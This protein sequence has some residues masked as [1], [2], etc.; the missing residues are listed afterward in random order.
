MVMF[1]LLACTAYDPKDSALST[2][3]TVGDSEIESSTT[4]DSP[5]T[6][7]TGTEPPP[8]ELVIMLT[9]DAMTRTFYS[10]REENYGWDITPF[11]D[12]LLSEGVLMPNV[13]SSRALTGVSLGTLVTGAWPKHT[14]IRDNTDEWPDLVPTIQD[15]FRANGYFTVMLASNRCELGEQ[16][17]DG[18]GWDYYE[19]FYQERDD[20]GPTQLEADATLVERFK[21]IVDEH[22]GEK[23]YVWMHLM[24]PHEDYETVE[25][26]FTEYHPEEYRGRL[27]GEIHQTIDDV[28]LGLAEYSDADAKYINAVYASAIRENDD[29]VR[30]VVDFLQERGLYDNTVLA[31][32]ADHGQEFATRPDKLYFWHG[33][34]Y[35]NIAAMVQWFIK[36]PTLPV[37]TLPG[38][39]RSVDIGPTMLDLAGI[40]ADTSTFDGESIRTHLED[41]SDPENDGFVERGMRAAGIVSGKYK[42]IL[43][44]DEAFYQC[45]PYTPDYEYVTPDVEL[46]DLDRDLWEFDNLVG[47]EP[48]IAAEMREKLCSYIM[49]DSWTGDVAEDETNALVRECIRG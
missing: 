33:C 45:T 3:D 26:W 22:P 19:C 49:E 5:T 6:T 42:Y 39:H 34:T 44:P 21:T 35:Y 13:L 18:F 32:G 4:D 20:K 11:Q 31:L 24:N 15:Q 38:Y 2:D 10:W 25:P 36:G 46:Y 8:A 27:D 14:G 29:H 43:N 17:E 41:L 16:R 30:D 12:S 47:R 9:Q 37:G 28:T 23:L 1:L 40:V 7:D 48:E